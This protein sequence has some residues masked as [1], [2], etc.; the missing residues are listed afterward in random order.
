M[1]QSSFKKI[2]FFILVFIL[3][4]ALLLRLYKF[5]IPLADLHSWRQA[6]TAAV[7]RNFVKNGFD[8]THPRYDDLSNVQSGL[9]NPQGYRMVEFPLYNAFFAYTYKL[10]PSI[11]IEQWGRLVSITFSLLTI[12]VIYFLVLKEK[13]RMTAFFS[14]FIYAVFPFFVFFSR[15]VLPESTA[16]GFTFLAIFFLYL[17]PTK[18]SILNTLFYMLSLL[19]FASALLIKPT[20]IF[21]SL[22]LAYLFFQSDKTKFLKKP[23][24]YFYFALSVIPLF[25]WRNYIKAFPEGIPVNEWLITSVN[26]GGGLQKIFL[27][28]A[29]FRWVFFERI[30]NL[31][32][33]GF[34]TVF[35]IL[36][37]LSKQK[38]YL[39]LTILLSSLVYLFVFEGGNVQH[40]YYQTLIL[41]SLAIFS[42]LGISF[43]IE[44]RKFVSPFFSFFMI[45]ILLAFSWFFSFYQVK[46]YYNHSQELVQ[47]AKILA[48]LTQ[49][50]DKIVTDRMGDTTL[51]YLAQR[52][53]APAFYREPESLQEFGY[54]YLI[55][56]SQEAIEKLKNRNYKLVFENDKFSLFKL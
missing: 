10:I 24:F 15:V 30:N 47:E 2:D 39:F 1:K 31:I 25:W 11:P 33:G 50:E 9:E 54:Q 35:L 34:S 13:D 29:F 51:L 21:F 45:P 42:A 53:G 27:R 26:T 49:P 23:F 7:A 20:V 44:N 37:I 46:N 43:L 4:I 12:S 22:P 41:P 5:N 19:F 3:F 55:T 56:S 16:L 32:L 17:R 38:K 52:H 18:Y 40:E 48:S 36:G 8:L 14:G 6:D 28:P